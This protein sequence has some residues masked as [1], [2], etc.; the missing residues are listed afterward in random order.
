VTFWHLDT[1]LFHMSKAHAGMPFDKGIVTPGKVVIVPAFMQFGTSWTAVQAL[2]GDE[3]YDFPRAHLVP[4][5]A[6]NPWCRSK[7]GASPRC[8]IPR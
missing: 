4:C 2:V 7:N 8:S 6:W 5:R 1:E 3:A